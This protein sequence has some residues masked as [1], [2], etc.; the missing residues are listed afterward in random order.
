MFCK[1]NSRNLNKA[2]AIEFPPLTGMWGISQFG[3]KAILTLLE[4]Y[5]ETYPPVGSS[6]FVTERA[7]IAVFTA[8]YKTSCLHACELTLSMKAPT[9]ITYDCSLTPE[10]KS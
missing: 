8:S 9:F 2:S 6:C 7:P 3:V 10:F 4:L 1:E 5:V